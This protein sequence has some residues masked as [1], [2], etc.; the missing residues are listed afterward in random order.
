MKTETAMVDTSASL[1]WN[2][3]WCRLIFQPT[4]TRKTKK[5]HREEPSATFT[6]TKEFLFLWILRDIL[7]GLYHFLNCNF[8]T[9]LAEQKHIGSKIDFGEI[10][11]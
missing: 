3:V 7:R 8:R 6:L 1:R 11:K 5:D 2:S 9:Q 4:K 10:Y